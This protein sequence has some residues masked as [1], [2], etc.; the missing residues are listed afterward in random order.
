[1]LAETTTEAPPE[2]VRD[3]NE[4]FYDGGYL[5]IDGWDLLTNAQCRKLNNA[6]RDYYGRTGVAPYIL[7]TYDT[8][9]VEEEKIYALY[10]N[11]F[12]DETH[13]LIVYVVTDEGADWHSLRGAEVYDLVEQGSFSGLADALNETYSSPAAFVSA[14]ADFFGEKE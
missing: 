10:D 7:I 14:L 2:N 11:L 1:M 5:C 13:L 3:E 9:L 6:M 4:F 12:S 8:D